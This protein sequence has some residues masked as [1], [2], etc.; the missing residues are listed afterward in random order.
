MLSAPLSIVKPETAHGL[1][2]D[3]CPVLLAEGTKT[4][5][6]RIPLTAVAVLLLGSQLQAQNSVPDDPQAL[7]FLVQQVR[8]LQ[9]ETIELRKQVKS[10]QEERASAPPIVAQTTLT[11]EL[12][13]PIQSYQSAFRGSGSST[14]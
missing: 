13:Q 11:P 5:M 14:A 1:R 12:S 8:D 7:S 9:R 10:L 4:T 2:E 6:L 3:G